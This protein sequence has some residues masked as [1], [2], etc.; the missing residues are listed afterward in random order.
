MADDSFTKPERDALLAELK[1]IFLRRFP[2]EPTKEP[3]DREDELLR[4]KYYLLL[5]EYAD[6]LPRVSLSVCPYCDEPLKRAFDPFGLDGPWWAVRCEVAIEEPRACEHFRLLQGALDLRGR[7]PVEADEQVQPGPPV[8]FLIPALM[9]L[10]GMKAVV[11]KVT[12]ATGDIAYP[13]AYFSNEETDPARLQQP[14]LRDT[15]WF[16]DGEGN[17]GWLIATY[18]YDFELEP[19]FK[20]GTLLWTDLSVEEPRV[21]GPREGPCPLLALPGE[22]ERQE[23]SG[24]EREL[25]GLPTG[26]PVVPFG[27]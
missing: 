13:I 15:H 17:A 1:A 14:W 6:R 25:M 24:G 16:K 2:D 11:S 8:P 27:D 4:E 5:G 26:E 19:Y 21:L 7:V 20:N 22:R 18:V 10:P 9:R 3:S 12:L 23:L